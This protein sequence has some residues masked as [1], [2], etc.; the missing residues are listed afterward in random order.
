MG[1][2]PLEIFGIRGHVSHKATILQKNLHISLYVALALCN[3]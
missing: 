1:V 3:A 2:P